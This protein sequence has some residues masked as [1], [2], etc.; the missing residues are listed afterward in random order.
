M[1]ETKEAENCIAQ[2]EQ[3][4]AVQA[5][6][7]QTTGQEDNMM[8]LKMMLWKHFLVNPAQDRRKG[9]LNSKTLVQP[10]T[11]ETEEICGRINQHGKPCQR[12]GRCPFHGIKEK[13]RK[14]LI[15]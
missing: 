5:N 6:V 15:L 10:K 7:E 1:N 2:Q 9:K 12:V 11:V 13:K 14:K 3:N 4:C 8:F